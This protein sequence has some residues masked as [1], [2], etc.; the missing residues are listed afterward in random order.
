GH[1][2]CESGPIRGRQPSNTVMCPVIRGPLARKGS[3]G[4]PRS[5]SQERRGSDGPSHSLAS[6]AVERLP[7]I[8]ILG[9][10]GT[11]RVTCALLRV[12][13][14]SE[15]FCGHFALQGEG[16]CHKWI[17]LF[18]DYFMRLWCACARIFNQCFPASLLDRASSDHHSLVA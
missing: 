7:D 16:F 12:L 5:L 6:E 4:P 18:E 11:V 10:V 1:V 17:V 9:R 13:C 8:N 14:A 2:L 15:R 3:H